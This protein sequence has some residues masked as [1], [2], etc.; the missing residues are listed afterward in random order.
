MA[1]NPNEF[2]DNAISELK[3]LDGT[4]IIAV[5]G[6]VDSTVCAVLANRAIGSKLKPIFVDT[7]FLRKGEVEQVKKVFKELGISVVTIDA[8]KE[9]FACLKGVVDP[10]EKRKKI[11][12]MFIRV[13]EKEAKH[14]NAKYLIQGTIAP[15]W[16]ESGSGIRD[17]IK[18]HHNVGGLPKQMGL[19]VV[20][21]IRE[22]Y[23]D[24]VR[25]IAKE[26][27]VP[28]DTAWKQP[29]PGPGLAIRI[30]GEIT[31]E[32][33]TL[34]REA[35]SIVMEEVFRAFEFG[36]MDLPWQYFAVLLETKTTGVQGDVRAY[37]FTVAIRAVE[38]S[39]GMTAQYFKIPHTVLHRIS[40]R[41]TNELKQ[42]NRVVYDIT[43]KPPAC[44]EWE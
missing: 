10:E 16:I 18:S 40:L 14:L 8:S 4:A 7:G 38:A 43:N 32:K 21:P 6:G 41:I 35:N 3:K 19:V 11:G 26:L 44:I 17:T 25:E 33:I 2:I 22:L 31:P 12:E 28:K 1:F 9:F 23:K 29:S 39:D 30:I 5:S 36:E 15:D 24:E 42:I 13:F 37:G 20:E 27:D 34:C